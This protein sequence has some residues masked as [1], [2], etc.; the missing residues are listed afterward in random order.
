MMETPLLGRP[1]MLLYIRVQLPDGKCVIESQ[2]RHISI[3]NHQLS[4]DIGVEIEDSAAWTEI[5]NYIV[6]LIGYRK[7]SGGAKAVRC[8]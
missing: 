1:G 3:S 8:G 7:K 5:Y 6:E 4:A 2:V